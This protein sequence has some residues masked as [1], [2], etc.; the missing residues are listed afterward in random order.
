MSNSPE[1]L[2]TKSSKFAS[3]T[4]DAELFRD[5]LLKME[6]HPKRYV[7]AADG[8]AMNA[9][10]NRIIVTI[11]ELK[12]MC[13]PPPGHTSTDI[14]ELN[15]S[16]SEVLSSSV[17]S[18]PEIE[19]N[20]SPLIDFSQPQV[21][22]VHSQSQTQQSPL[23][24]VNNGTADTDHAPDLALSSATNAINNLVEEACANAQ[25][26][27]RTKRRRPNILSVSIAD[28]NFED[29]RRTVLN[30]IDPSE[31]GLRIDWSGKGKSEN[32]IIGF[33][34][35]EEREKARRLLVSAG[36]GGLAASPPTPTV[37]GSFLPQN[38]SINEIRKSL[39]R[40]NSHLGLQHDKWN[41]VR[42]I[43]LNCGL[44]HYVFSAPS[45]DVQKTDGQK[46]Y[47]GPSR[48]NFQI[49]PRRKQTQ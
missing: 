20:T 36:I 12:L 2:I 28:K 13:L 32:V 45:A 35:T 3:L 16:Y 4:D 15:R 7:L 19:Q 33:R 9:T 46:L 1:Q 8:R 27:K 44:S 26:R 10:I 14:T 47:I 23:S 41:I 5:Y 48:A 6:S 38:L 18:I 43:K 22:S 21:P 24:T 11:E 39:S 30:Q 31:N 34:S 37:R 42:E 17:R 40:Q 49:R 25:P 29:A